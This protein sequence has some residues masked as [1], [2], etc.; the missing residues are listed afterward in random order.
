MKRLLVELQTHLSQQDDLKLGITLHSMKGVAGLIGAIG[1]TKLLANYEQQVKLGE[2][3]S[4]YTAEQMNLEISESI[5]FS[6]SLLKEQFDEKYSF[7][8]MANTGDEERLTPTKW[9]SLLGAIL[10]LLEANNMDAFDYADEVERNSPDDF[11]SQSHDV[12]ENLRLLKFKQAAAIVKAI[13][14][15]KI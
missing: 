8:D 9:F 4:Q 3:K 12:A 5:N 14:G 7:K 15:A 10:P 13:L 2:V 1:L 6:L 11:V